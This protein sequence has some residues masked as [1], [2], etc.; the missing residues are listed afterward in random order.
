MLL[1]CCSRNTVLLS[2]V[3]LIMQNRIQWSKCW[4]FLV[5]FSVTGCLMVFVTLEITLANN[6]YIYGDDYFN[7]NVCWANTSFILANNGSDCL[8]ATSTRKTLSAFYVVYLFFTVVSVATF[9]FIMGI[10]Y[11]WYR[12]KRAS[13]LRSP[14][15]IGHSVAKEQSFLIFKTTF[16]YAI[17]SMV[18]IA[19]FIPLLLAQNQL[20]FKGPFNNTNSVIYGVFYGLYQ[21][22]VALLNVS[23]YGIFCKTFRMEVRELF[24]ITIQNLRK[25]KFRTRDD[26]TVYD[27]I[28]NGKI[29]QSYSLLNNSAPSH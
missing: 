4:F 8:I 19:C 26:D 7:H 1:H 9:S 13:L 12:R 17:T 25:D 16:R 3:L 24:V 6:S 2:Y 21:P 11:R 15:S 27:P 22:I 28:I 5:C 29:Q 20:A 10:A 23:V 18:Y 14:S